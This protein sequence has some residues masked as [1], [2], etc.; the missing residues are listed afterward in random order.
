MRKSKK[1]CL[2]ELERVYHKPNHPI[3]FS[4]LDKIYR[5]FDGVLTKKAIS[6]FLHTQESYLAH[7]EY[8]KPK[9]RNPTYVLFKRYQFQLDLIE[10]SNVRQYNGQFCFIMCAIDIWSKF[11]WARLLYKKTAQETLAAFKSILSECGN[12]P[13]SIA[14]DRGKEWN[15]STMLDYCKQKGIKITF[16]D[17]SVHASIVERFNLTLQRRIFQFMTANSTFSFYA[18][19]QSIIDG[20]NSSFHRSIH[21]TPNFAEQAENAW[22]VRKSHERRYSKVKAKKSK[23]KSGQHVRISVQKPKFFRGYDKTSTD[24]TFVVHKVYNNLPIPLIELKTL[25]NSEV[26]KGKFYPHE[27]ILSKR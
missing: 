24:E 23:F 9:P 20:Y 14:V 1:S 7:F 27:I 5:Y 22:F 10:I 16:C 21:C 17:T 8:K 11:A 13:K 3:S 26:L 4:G 18:S 25:D 19:L 15:N 2:E 12:L 6:N